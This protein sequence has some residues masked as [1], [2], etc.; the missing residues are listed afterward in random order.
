[1]GRVQLWDLT[2][3][4]NDP[5]LTSTHPGGVHSAAWSP[6]SSR[7][8]TVGGDAVIKLWDPTTGKSQDFRLNVSPNDRMLLTQSYGLTWADEKHWSVV[9][10]KGEIQRLDA[11]LGQVMPAGR[12][13]PRDMLARAGLMAAPAG[14]FIWAPGGKLLASVDPKG[15]GFGVI[16][17]DVKI[18]DA[19]T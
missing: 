4:K 2:L 15:G 9:V 10:G 8:A 11:S 3:D 19:A 12:L 7:L 17:A 5:L 14:R 18:W 13:V 1:N 16:S 6:D